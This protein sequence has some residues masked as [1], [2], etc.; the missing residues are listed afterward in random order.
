M[1]ARSALA[2]QAFGIDAPDVLMHEGLPPLSPGARV[3][4]WAASGAL[5]QGVD[6]EV[7]WRESGGLRFGYCRMRMDGDPADAALRVYRNIFASLR[8]AACGRIVRM[9][10]YLPHINAGSGDQERYR[11]FCLGRARA[12][13]E[14][15]DMAGQWPAGTAVGALSGEDLLVSFLAGCGEVTPV[16]NPRQVHAYEYPRDYGPR[17]PLFS[18][19]TVCRYAGADRL[20][21]SGTASIVGHRSEHPGDPEAQLA[22]TWRNLEALSDAVEGAE[23]EALRVYLRRPADLPVAQRFL[24]ERLPAACAVLYLQADICRAELLLEIEGLYRLAASAHRHA[25]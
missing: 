8:N 19:A 24:A 18:R 9:W 10:N 4:R 3:E 11:R 12:F 1:D 7:H 25:S 13:D 17:S 23:P 14:A 2:A 5:A 22:E 15:P 20:F 16:E 6:G 21:V